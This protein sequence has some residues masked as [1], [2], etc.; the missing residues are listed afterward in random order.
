MNRKHK[1]DELYKF[2]KE[3]LDSEGKSIRRSV[4]YGAYGYRSGSSFRTIKE[5]LLIL[6]GEGLIHMNT[7]FLDPDIL[8]VSADP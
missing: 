2:I 3:Q 8:L 4:L 5:F 1:I 7:F 6:R